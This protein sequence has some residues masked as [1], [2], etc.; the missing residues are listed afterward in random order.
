MKELVR[1][2]NLR[3]ERCP[4]IRVIKTDENSGNLGGPVAINGLE[5]RQRPRVRGRERIDYGRIVAVRGNF[6]TAAV[7][8]DHF[9]RARQFTGAGQ[10][11][12]EYVIRA[13][14]KDVGDK[15]ARCLDD[16]VDLTS[17]VCDRGNPLLENEG[18]NSGVVIET[19]DRICRIV[20]DLESTQ[21]PPVA[22][23]KTIPTRR[24]CASL[25][26]VGQLDRE[27][28]GSTK[29]ENLPLGPREE[30]CRNSDSP[31]TVSVE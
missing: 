1:S 26:T 8:E 28:F 6:V 27:S 30:W 18:I 24:C 29:G 15:L 31:V 10:M 13:D 21:R 4:F 20:D 5:V 14:E 23:R 19:P 9:R 17:F 12:I 3:L 25:A 11:T 22:A 2:I 7:D 16:L